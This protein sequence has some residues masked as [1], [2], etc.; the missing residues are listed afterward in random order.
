MGGTLCL[1]DRLRTDRG[2]GRFGWS[3]IAAGVGSRLVRAII[4]RD[5]VSGR[6]VGWR[7]L[8]GRSLFCGSFRS[9]RLFSR[10]LFCGSFLSG[11]LFSRGLFCGS[12]L[13]GSGL[14]DRS[15][16]DDLLGGSLFFRCFGLCRLVSHL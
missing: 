5:V 6:L 1:A 15:F 9:G 12:F 14:F 7:F 3:F 13:S 4:G 2:C 16:G 8:S 11:R 10:G